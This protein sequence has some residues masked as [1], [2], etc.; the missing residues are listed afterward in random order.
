[1]LTLGLMEGILSA[2]LGLLVLVG[3]ANENAPL[4]RMMG[5]PVTV[6]LGMVAYGIYA[7]GA[8]STIGDVAGLGIF[9]I[10]A[11]F[12]PLGFMRWAWK[13]TKALEGAPTQR[14]SRR[15]RLTPRLTPHTVI[16]SPPERRVA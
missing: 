5:P 9:A 1:M 16:E 15:V 7:S 14:A 6:L 8:A 11:F 10:L 12:G 3:L 13:Q 2:T 4:H